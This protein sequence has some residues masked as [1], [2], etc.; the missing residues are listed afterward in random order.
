M[1]GTEFNSAAGGVRQDCAGYSFASPRRQTNNHT[2]VVVVSCTI[3]AAPSA[4]G[5]ARGA[6][7]THAE[8]IIE[9]SVNR[10]RTL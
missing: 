5:V 1:H 7:S 8:G 9:V 4:F 10:S 3:T 2:T 6:G